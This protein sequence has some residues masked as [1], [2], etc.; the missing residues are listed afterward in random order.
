[1]ASSRM[2]KRSRKRKK[3]QPPNWTTL[4]WSESCF[5]SRQKI[6]QR[7]EPDTDDLDPTP[8]PQKDTDVIEQSVVTLLSM[9]LMPT[10][11]LPMCCGRISGEHPN[12]TS[13]GRLRIGCIVCAGRP[14]SRTLG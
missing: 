6:R 10:R 14:E 13:A 9:H 1:M 11:C 4:D 7:E 2:A 3:H 8:A 12:G 5:L